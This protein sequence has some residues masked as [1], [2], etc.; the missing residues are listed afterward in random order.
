MTSARFFA[1]F[2]EEGVLFIVVGG[3]SAVLQG[4][5]VATFDLA[6][7]H[8]RTAQNVDRLIRALEQ[9]DA[10]YRV[11]PERRLRP[12]AT[13]L[14]SPGHQLP[15][16][17]CGPLDLLGAIGDSFSYDDLISNTEVMQ[18]SGFPVRVLSLEA[19]IR[20]KEALGDEKDHATLPALR[21]ALEQKRE[22]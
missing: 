7:V 2:C 12:N 20:I 3:V 6:V 22:R 1:S 14:T 8:S 9:L 5:P 19:S 21:R 10:C 15:L 16:T 13:H 4:A 11:Q 18:I 17:R